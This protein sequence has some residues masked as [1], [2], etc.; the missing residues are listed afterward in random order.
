MVGG[1]WWQRWLWCGQQHGAG[2]RMGTQ[3]L[4]W[5]HMVMQGHTWSHMVTPAYEELLSTV[6]SSTRLMAWDRKVWNE[7]RA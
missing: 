3:G 1:R 2:S 5:S 7:A 6:P 4:T